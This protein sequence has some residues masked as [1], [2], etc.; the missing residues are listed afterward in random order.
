MDF[1]TTM[2]SD[3]KYVIMSYMFPNNNSDIELYNVLLEYCYQNNSKYWIKSYVDF[4]RFLLLKKY[5]KYENYYV[6]V[7][8]RE[9]DHYLG[10]CELLDALFTGCNLPY[11][12]GTFSIYTPSIELD[13]RFMVS[14]LPESI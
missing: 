12:R 13:I 5:K 8:K 11:G 7:S 10:G 9:S 2:N 4:N 1:L 3:M 6:N 14:Y